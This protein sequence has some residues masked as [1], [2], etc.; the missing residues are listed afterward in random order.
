MDEELAQ[1]RKDLFTQITYL[2]KS[3]GL[4][5]K[6]DTNK[7]Y[8]CVLELRFLVD[9]LDTDDLKLFHDLEVGMGIYNLYIDRE[10]MMVSRL[11]RYIEK[12]N[13]G[14]CYDY[15]ELIEQL[16]YLKDANSRLFEEGVNP[17][18]NLI[19][20]LDIKGGNRRRRDD[21]GSETL[22]DVKNELAIYSTK[23]DELKR[24]LL[25]NLYAI[26]VEKKY[27]GRPRGY[28]DLEWWK[29]KK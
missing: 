24:K 21:I 15:D 19:N 18:I 4:C 17:K 14:I 5:D 13:S 3:K 27:V 23:L 1:V 25:R 11:L 2:R 26:R 16:P 8:E 12:D 28:F 22:Q 10:K 7:I 6:L 20:I 9:E 29:S